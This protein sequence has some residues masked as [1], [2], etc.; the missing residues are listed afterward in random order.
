MGIQKKGYALTYI[1]LAIVLAVILASSL[2]TAVFIHNR[3]LTQLQYNKLAF[4]TACTGV[5]Y[6]LYIVK[7]GHY[8]P[9]ENPANWPPLPPGVTINMTS[10]GATPPVYV[11][12]S[13]GL[14]S[15]VQK[16]ITVTCKQT[17]E[18]ISWQTS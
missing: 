8:S 9:P 3:L 2:Y 16:N 10:N 18:V 14:N 4:Y 15:G 5:E 6:G 12:K 17:G 13:T 11:I 1:I 7:S